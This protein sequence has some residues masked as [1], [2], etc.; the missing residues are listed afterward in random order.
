[1]LSI[2]AIIR[3]A[4]LRD[5]DN[6][7]YNGK[8]TGMVSLYRRMNFCYREEDFCLNNAHVPCN[9]TLALASAIPPL[10]SA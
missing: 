8:F 10:D 5:G 3:T 6:C 2:S 7:K 9:L 4:I 1:M